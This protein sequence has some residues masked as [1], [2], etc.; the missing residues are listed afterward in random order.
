[1][2][3]ALKRFLSARY[4]RDILGESAVQIVPLVNEDGLVD[5]IRAEIARIDAL[6]LGAN[7]ANRDF[8]AY[9]DRRVLSEVLGGLVGVTGRLAARE[10]RDSADFG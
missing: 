5:E 9:Q 10:A 1:M 8:V 2:R 6:R 3:M 4:R 7:L